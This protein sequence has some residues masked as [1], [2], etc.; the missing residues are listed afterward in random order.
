MFSLRSDAANAAQSGASL[1]SLPR[2]APAKERHPPCA[3][4]S[5]PTTSPSP[6]AT[7]TC[8]RSRSWRSGQS[9][10]RPLEQTW[11]VRTEAREEQIEA[12][13]RGLLDPDD[14]LLIQ[15]SK[16]E[17]VLTNTALRWF[18]QRR[19]GHGD[20]RG[21]QHH[22]LPDAA[23]VPRRPARNCRSP[24]PAETPAEF[25]SERRCVQSGSGPFG[26]GPAVVSGAMS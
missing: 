25:A 6:T 23:A 2:E 17:A 4:S 16:D 11:Y 21:H 10:A 20:R 5:S 26:S 8:S 12:Q 15:A 24:R 14:G 22:R 9:W 3:P 18:R 19:A 13:L 7:S 1:A